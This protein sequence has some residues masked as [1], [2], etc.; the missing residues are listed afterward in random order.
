MGGGNSTYSYALGSPLNYTDSRGLAP[1]EDEL[2][3]EGDPAESGPIVAMQYADL[4]AQ[5]REYD[6][7]YQ[8]VTV[9]APNSAPTRADVQRLQLELYE[10]RYSNVCPAPRTSNAFRRKPGSL[11]MFK[12]TDALRAEN[13]VLA[14][15]AQAAG[16]NQDQATQLHDEISGQN[17]S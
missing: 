9:H 10:L 13:R 12:G 3:P 4:L 8:D 1:E 5:I 2:P 16:L 7:T 17:L 6:Q 15:A 14:D 11:G